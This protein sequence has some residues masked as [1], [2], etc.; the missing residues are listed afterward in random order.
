LLLSSEGN[1][2]KRPCTFFL[3]QA[4]DLGNRRRYLDLDAGSRP[5]QSDSL[6]RCSGLDDVCKNTVMVHRDDEGGNA[7]RLVAGGLK[8]AHRFK[9]PVLL[10]AARGV[11]A[12]VG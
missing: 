11:V 3:L 12:S 5:F 1:E 6:V 7:G 10:L 2:H 9:H 4:V 8:G